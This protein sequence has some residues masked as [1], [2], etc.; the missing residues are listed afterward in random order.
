MLEQ[1]NFY[2]SWTDYPTVVFTREKCN[3]KFNMI[4]I[5]NNFAFV[6]IVLELHHGF[7]ITKLDDCIGTNLLQESRKML[8]Q[9]WTTFRLI[10]A[11]SEHILQKLQVRNSLF[12]MSVLLLTFRQIYLDLIHTKRFNQPDPSQVTS[13]SH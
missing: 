9:H 1:H 4:W 2:H 12:R 10:T 11:L 7:I 5:C 6:A 8:L 13:S 3:L